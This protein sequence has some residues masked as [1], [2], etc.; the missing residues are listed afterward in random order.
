MTNPKNLAVPAHTDLLPLVAESLSASTGPAITAYELGKLVYLKGKSLEI[1]ASK[2]EYER[3]MDALLAVR[4]LVKISGARSAYLLFGHSAA[5][6]AEIACCLDPFA[7]VSHLSAMEHHGLTDRFPK[8][9]YLT[10]PPA[11]E[12]RKQAKARMAR[13]LAEDL[14]AY[15][16]SGLPRLTLPALSNL[17]GTTIHVHERSQF[18]AFRNVA[19][20]PLRVATIGRVFLDMLREPKSCGGMQHVIDVYRRE[21]KRNLKLIV[22][23]VSRHGQSIDK[24]RAGYVLT[25]V[26]HLQFDAASEWQT[27]AQ[28]GGSRKLDPDGEYV[29]NYSETWKLSI[30]VPSLS[31]PEQEFDDA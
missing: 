22:D 27:Y 18:G 17:L 5:S 1:E 13:D 10:R 15:K 6:P 19:G 23:E 25:E 21:A 24:V 9:L 29:S 8:I 12:W 4:L 28:R 26:C 11:I 31:S 16:Q 3:V 14:V 20:S 7:Y 30:N 2:R